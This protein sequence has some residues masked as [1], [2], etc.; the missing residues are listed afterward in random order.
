LF[1][2]EHQAIHGAFANP[3]AHVGPTQFPV[4]HTPSLTIRHAPGESAACLRYRKKHVA[5]RDA[6]AIQDDVY[7]Y[8]YL[9]LDLYHIYIFFKLH[10]QNYDDKTSQGFLEFG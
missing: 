1:S 8:I 7:I 2:D 10:E 5:S 9:Y 4:V 6:M 3:R